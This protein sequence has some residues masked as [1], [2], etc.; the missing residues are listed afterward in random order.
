MFFRLTNSLATFQTMMDDIFEDLIT[1]DVVVVYL[2]DILIFTKT[3]EEHWEV[4][5]RVLDLLQFHHLSLKP[6]KCEFE[7]MSIEWL[8]VVISQDSI[9]MDPAKVTRVS[10]WPTPTTKKA[11]QLFS[12]F[13]NFYRRFIEGF[14]HIARPLL[15]LA[16]NNS[17]FQWSSYKQST[18]NLLKEKVTL[19]PIL[20]LHNSSKPFCIE[21]DSLDFASRAVLSQQS[22]NNDKWHPVALLSKSLSPVERNYKI[23]DKEMLAIVRAL[24]EW[25]HFVEG[26][27]HQIKIW[28]DHKNLEYFMTAKEL[29]RRQACWSLLPAQFDFIMHHRPRKTMGKSDTLG[30]RS[31]HSS[32]AKD[33]DN[34]ILLTL[35]FFA[36]QAL[37]GLEMLG[38]EK[39]ILKEIRHQTNSRSKKEVVVKAIKEL[40]RS[41][42]KSVKLSEWSLDNGI[43]Y[44]REKVYVPN[45]D[46]RCHISTL[47][48]DS[49]I[50]GHAGRWKTLELVSRNYWWP[51][52]LRYISRY[53]STRDMCLRTKASQQS[54]VRELHLL[55][56]SNAP[57]DTISVDFIVELPESEGKD[58]V[59]VVVDSV[60]KCGRFVDTL[61]MLSAAGM[62]RLYIQH[63]W[64]HHSLPKVV[65]NRGPQF[66]AEFITDS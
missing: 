28:T 35:D 24:E 43:L 14:S 13:V 44:H 45:S 64:K 47:C 51:Q 4:V 12:G 66:I 46:L 48:H 31:D 62:V 37:E 8:G 49:K 2:D 60:T 22:P 9:M 41:S 38:E 59:M 52:M 42:N 39:D 58:A 1:E 57:W 54:P 17:D 26:T 36:I 65:S 10:E 3:L 19:A 5:C 40:M 55:P 20:A 56:I 53:F 50:A 33:N 16:K 18:F 7:K 21:A 61:T 25:R 29:N 15:N 27:E 30:W 34:I 6:E 11:V 32:G 23:H 63:I